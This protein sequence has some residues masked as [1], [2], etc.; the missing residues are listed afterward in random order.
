MGEFSVR[1][2]A[3]L[4]QD[5]EAMGRQW[6]LCYPRVLLRNAYVDRKL[7]RQ[8]AILPHLGIFPGPGSD[9]LRLVF[10]CKVLELDVVAWAGCKKHIWSLAPPV[11]QLEDDSGRQS[12][13]SPA[14]GLGR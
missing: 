14:Y 10:M 13:Y 9:E 12:F 5:F 3:S 8:A 1:N 6:T 11:F 2:L 4:V 7:Q